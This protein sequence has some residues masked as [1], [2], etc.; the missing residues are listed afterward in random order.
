M[1][2]QSVVGQ[3]NGVGNKWL[4]IQSNVLFCPQLKDIQFTVD[5]FTRWWMN[6]LVVAALTDIKDKDFM[7][8][9]DT[10]KLLFVGMFSLSRLSRRQTA[11]MKDVEDNK[12][13]NVL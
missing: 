3:T 11:S 8:C 5:H 9:I 13:V 1:D 6:W 2:H 4:F 12:Y 10:N 7:T